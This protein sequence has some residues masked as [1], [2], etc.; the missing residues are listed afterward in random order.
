PVRLSPVQCF[1]EH[2]GELLAIC[3][4]SDKTAYQVHF[5]PGE[6]AAAVSHNDECIEKDDGCPE[7]FEGSPQRRLSRI[8]VPQKGL[9]LVGGK[10]RCRPPVGPEVE[11]PFGQPLLAEPI[12]L[13]IITDYFDGRAAS[14]A[15]D[16][17]VA[18]KRVEVEALAYPREAVDPLSEVDRFDGHEDAHLGRDLDHPKNTLTSS[19]TSQPPVMIIL[20]PV[21]FAIS[22]VT[23][24]GPSSMKAGTPLSLPITERAS[25]R[26]LKLI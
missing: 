6:L 11:P 8:L 5:F 19:P 12:S 1:A 14:A 13:A 2:P 18:A 23:V 26:A 10:T 4:R 15:K 16:E 17:E 21:G 22:M 25:A 7:L 20:S 9:E 24:S 3:A